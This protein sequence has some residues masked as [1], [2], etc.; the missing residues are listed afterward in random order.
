MKI[1]VIGS[2]GREHALCWKI[3]RSPKCSELY[4]APGNGGIRNVARLVDICPEN[5]E[6]LLK[7]AKDKA[8][9]LTVVGPE[10]P[11]VA[12]LVDRF[13]KADLKAFGPTQDLARIEGS[14][15]FSKELM[16]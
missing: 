12:G 11:L 13:E 15:V 16:K 8:I 4:C 5:V 10:M 2:G 1:L 6:G 9:D 3:A 14:K 7:F